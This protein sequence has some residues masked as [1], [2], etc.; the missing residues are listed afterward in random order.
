MRHVGCYRNGFG[1]YSK[2]RVDIADH[3]DRF[4]VGDDCYLTL[5]PLLLVLAFVPL[6]KRRVPTYEPSPGS[7]A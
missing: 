1:Y 5:L 2:D 3:T 6:P 7:V 4:L